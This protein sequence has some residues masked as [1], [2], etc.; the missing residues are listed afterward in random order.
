M[1]DFEKKWEK[2]PMTKPYVAKVVANIGVGSGGDQLVPALKLLEKLT[3][4]KPVQTYSKHMS[5]PGA[6][7]TGILSH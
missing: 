3:G 4:K 6:T 5:P 2:E 1:T 7:E